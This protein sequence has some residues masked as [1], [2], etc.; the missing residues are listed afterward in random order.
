MSGLPKLPTPLE[1]RDI[2]Y[3]RETPAQRLEEYGHAYLE[4]GLINDA[5]EFFGVAKSRE[6][7]ELVR[8]F[9]VE[10]GDFF[11]LSRVVEFWPDAVSPEVWR[12]LGER[13]YQK[14]KL[15]FAL[16]AFEKSGDGERS[17]EVRRVIGHNGETREGQN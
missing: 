1:R 11:L 15:Q 16:K 13:A 5:V 4:E 3:G 2:L 7:L 10:E 9:A 14:G 17:A 6:G 8:R 12:E